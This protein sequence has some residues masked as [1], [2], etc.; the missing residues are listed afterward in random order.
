MSVSSLLPLSWEVSYYQP[1]PPLSAEGS[2]LRPNLPFRRRSISSSFVVPSIFLL[3][4]KVLS[5]Y[6]KLVTEVFEHHS[7]QRLGQY[8]NNFLID[9]HILELDSSILYHIPYI[10]ISDYYMLRFVMEHQI[11]CHI[12]TT[13][14]VIENHLVSNSMSNNPDIRF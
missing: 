10:K 5:N 9:T 3:V 7:R 12:Y 1:T 14:V 6:T 4:R 8:I 11:L 13:L 2:S